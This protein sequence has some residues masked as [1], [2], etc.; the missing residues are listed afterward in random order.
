MDGKGRSASKSSSR[1]HRGA[2]F[3][4]SHL[5]SLHANCVAEEYG[6]WDCRRTGLVA[7]EDAAW[8]FQNEFRLGQDDAVVAGEA[9]V[10]RLDADRDG[11]ISLDDFALS[12]KLT[13]VPPVPASGGASDKAAFRGAVLGALEE[14]AGPTLGTGCT[15]T[16]AIGLARLFSG[17]RASIAAAKELR[18]VVK[19]ILSDGHDRSRWRILAIQNLVEYNQGAASSDQFENGSSRIIDCDGRPIL[20][21]AGNFLRSPCQSAVMRSIGLVP[22]EAGGDSNERTRRQ[23]SAGVAAGAGEG[24]EDESN[25]SASP[26]GISLPAGT[27]ALEFLPGESEGWAQLPPSVRSV[28]E[29]MKSVLDERCNLPEVL[30]RI[31]DCAAAC[32]GSLAAVQAASRAM[33]HNIRSSA[34]FGRPSGK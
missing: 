17:V 9:L 12:S 10:A 30:G 2:S 7:P 15:V 33:A 4:S 32:N 16:G 1:G 28:L 14:A 26:W 18:S 22:A 31:P 21:L 3:P 13:F 29:Q 8:R 34:A 24:K 6:R 20:L 25:I 19:W 27:I 5:V 11:L 23:R